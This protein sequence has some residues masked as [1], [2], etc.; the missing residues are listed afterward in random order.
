MFIL[1]YYD[2]YTYNEIDQSL[3]FHSSTMKITSAIIK[4]NRLSC[5]FLG[6]NVNKENSHHNI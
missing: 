5:S 3:S 6:F 1:L 2:A 4:F